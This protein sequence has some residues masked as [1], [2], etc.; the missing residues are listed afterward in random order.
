MNSPLAIVFPG[1]GS[2]AIGMFEPWRH[3]ATFKQTIDEAS[4][5]VEVDL[6]RLTQ[7]GPAERL[8]DTRVTQVLMV[9]AGIAV[10]RAWQAAGGPQPSCSA[11][12]SVG[13]IAALIAADAIDLRPGIQLVRARAAAMA[14]AVAPNTAG[15][16]AVLGL[17]DAVVV[18]LC[19]ETSRPGMAEIV[20]AANFNAAGQV[21][22]AGHLAAIDR[23]AAAA[24]AAGA[25][26]V[27]R[28]PVSGPFHSSLMAPAVPVFLQALQFTSFSAPRF[29]VLHNIDARPAS[30]ASI[31]PRLAAHLTRPV[32]WADTVRRFVA[33]GVTRIV[34][35]GTGEVLTNL[36][37]RLVARAEPPVRVQSACTPEA[38]EQALSAAAA[39]ARQDA[40]TYLTQ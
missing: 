17:D 39:E 26:M 21:V 32:R 11:G 31:Q 7:D 10:W 29:D 38:L 16:A 18:R 36:N 34:E 14:E 5:A 4:D 19:D 13:E 6:W 20:E 28:L 30:A 23:L 35:M 15:M 2:Q 9:A 12:H 37:K 22:V 27:V 3:E 25:K 8:S 40:T 24:D 33:C 1:Q